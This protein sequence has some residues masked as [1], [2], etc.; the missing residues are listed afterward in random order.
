M[1]GAADLEDA[2][3]RARLGEGTDPGTAYLSGTDA[4]VAACDALTVP[5]VTGRAD[6]TVIDKIIALA[7]AGPAPLSAE[8][9]QAHRCA[10]ARLAIDFVSGPG[11]LAS[12]LRTGLLERPYSTPSFPLDKHRVLRL[13]PRAHP[14]RGHAPRPALRVARRLRPARL[15]F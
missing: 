7:S 14:P 10:I 6:M 4:E 8:A 11:G 12:A 3:L 5:V 13:H 1:P 2:W 9:R 15:S